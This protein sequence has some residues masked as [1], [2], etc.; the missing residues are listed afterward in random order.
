MQV[1]ATNK[2]EK[3][4]LETLKIANS[5]LK[6]KNLKLNSLLEITNAINNNFSTKQ[7]LRI[8]EFV[9]RNQL[10]IGKLVLYNFDVKW[11]CALKYGVNGEF[12][13]I[14]I[15]K[16]LI[17]FKE[18]TEVKDEQK[19]FLDNFEVVIPVYH[20]TIPLAYLLIGD[21]KDDLIENTKTRHIP[22]I[23]TLTNIIIVAI[24]NKKLANDNIRQATVKKEMELASEMQ[25]M[26]FPS[27]LPKDDKLEVAAHYQPHQMVGGDYYDFIRLNDNE[28]VFCMADV[29][30]KG[31]SAALL[32]SNFQANIRTMFNYTSSLTE[33]VQDLNT[34]VLASAKGEKF[35]TLF[36]AKYN[37]V[38]R[39]MN[40]VNAGQSPPLFFSDKT[41]SLLT[42]GCPGV[43]M[44]DELSSIKEGIINVSKNS[45]LLC[46][47][48]GVV[49]LE[50]DHDREFGFSKLE[51]L[52]LQNQ[53][54]GMEE[55]NKIIVE[56][57]SKYK[58]SKPY[59]DDIALFSIRFL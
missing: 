51:L 41:T 8:F 49:E 42:I 50:N 57:L 20:K 11:N 15:D 55:L 14:D 26:L 27:S 58:G 6:L 56:N 43:G 28:V 21:I 18:I 3:I 9:L 2:N 39:V 10:N 37:F 25:S 38:T 16:Q 48:D 29:S 44:L 47:T 36:V 31:V 17:V 53:N 30:G 5:A 23:Q 22:F 12:T 34:R 52:L 24:E 4:I 7:L 35:I 45:I 40:Y 1:T 13:D 46:Y 33:L 19:L 32:M 59:I 54:A